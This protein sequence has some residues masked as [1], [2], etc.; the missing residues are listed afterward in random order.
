[1]HTL[2][3][4]GALASTLSPTLSRTTTEPKTAAAATPNPPSSGQNTP[5]KSPIRHLLFGSMHSVQTTIQRLHQLGYAEP[6]DWSRPIPTGK[7]GEVMTVLT[8]RASAL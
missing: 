5:D 4:P 1:M 2:S 7:P 8:K 3:H 6:N